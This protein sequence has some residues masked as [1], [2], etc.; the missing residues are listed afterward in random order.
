[1]LLLAAPRIEPAQSMCRLMAGHMLRS[2][3]GDHQGS[4]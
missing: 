1:M 2:D 3:H 4:C